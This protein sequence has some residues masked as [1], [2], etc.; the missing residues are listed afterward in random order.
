M[1][2]NQPGR[3]AP[4]FILLFLAGEKHYGATLLNKM[5]EQMPHNRLDS[6]AIYRT[7]QELEKIGAVESYW[8]TS[9]PGPAKKWYQITE[10]GYQKL[11][12]YKEDIEK[13]KENLDFFLNT[14]QKLSGEEIRR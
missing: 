6:A 14:Y 12:Q 5:N 8:D 3:H 4:A 10:I 13:R 1:S 9:E 11:A 2:R 7:L